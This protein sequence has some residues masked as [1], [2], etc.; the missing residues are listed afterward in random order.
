ML[1]SGIFPDRDHLAM[2][3]K[4][5]WPAK[6]GHRQRVFANESQFNRWLGE[7]AGPDM[8]GIWIKLYYGPDWMRIK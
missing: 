4:Y 5:L 3:S 8:R 2:R 7:H 6:Q 1:A